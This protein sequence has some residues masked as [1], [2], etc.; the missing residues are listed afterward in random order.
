MW[1]GYINTLHKKQSWVI[2]E[3]ITI[4]ATLNEALSKYP[5][6]EFFFE[7]QKKLEEVFGIGK[8]NKDDD[9]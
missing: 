2:A 6:V 4:V 3:K 1:Q 5:N 9:E 8:R 7:F